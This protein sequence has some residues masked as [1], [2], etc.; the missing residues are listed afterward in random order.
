MPS[1]TLPCEPNWGGHRE[2]ARRMGEEYRYRYKYGWLGI[3]VP[4]HIGDVQRPKGRK[5]VE[6][7][8]YMVRVETQIKAL[9]KVGITRARVEWRGVRDKGRKSMLKSLKDGKLKRVSAR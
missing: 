8:S 1:A 6:W 4:G 9:M 5:E 7:S 3:G 2:I